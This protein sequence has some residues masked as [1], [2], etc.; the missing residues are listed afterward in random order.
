MHSDLFINFIFLD[1]ILNCFSIFVFNVSQ[2][3]CLDILLRL[4]IL[5]LFKLKYL[6]IIKLIDI[7]LNKLF[8]LRFKL[9]LL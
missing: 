4:Q 2:Y 8:Y 9:F 3:F 7:G 1:K 6:F 5:D